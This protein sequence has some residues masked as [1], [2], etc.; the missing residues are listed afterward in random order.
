MHPKVQSPIHTLKLDHNDIGDKGVQALAT[1]LCMN[2]T[3][4]SLSLTYCNITEKG[5]RALFEI[6]IYT[7]S[8]LK[9]LNLSGNSLKN[10]GI[11][12]IMKGL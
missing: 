5:S 12:I 9:E 2:A 6:I 8:Q 1:G 7:K 10:E 4:N 11:P 3:I